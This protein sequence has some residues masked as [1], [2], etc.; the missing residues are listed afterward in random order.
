MAMAA[1]MEKS[2]YLDKVFDQ[3]LYFLCYRNIYFT[4]EGQAQSK[5]LA[6]RKAAIVVLDE[7]KR[8]IEAEEK[9]KPQQGKGKGR[10][11]KKSSVI[12]ET[13][14][15]TPDVSLHPVSRLAQ[16]QQAAKGTVSARE[17]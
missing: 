14:K 3:F 7:M 12:K 9:E 2:K 5:K 16:I 10:N 8:V 17:S 15:L 6:R 13:E 4:A 1:R 11:K